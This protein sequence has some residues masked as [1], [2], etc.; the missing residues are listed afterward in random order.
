MFNLTTLQKQAL[1]Q[2]F[3]F[4]PIS[5]AKLS[6]EWLGRAKLTIYRQVLPSKAF[7][8]CNTFLKALHQVF[9]FNALKLPPLLSFII[10]SHHFEPWH[11]HTSYTGRCPK[12]TTQ[13]TALRRK[14][15]P[16]RP[17][18]NTG[19]TT[20]PICCERRPAS[21]KANWPGS[22]QPDA[23]RGEGHTLFLLLTN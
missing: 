20:S 2:F 4:Y 7:P 13:D 6:V 14:T 11:T 21:S 23:E 3:F 15:Q 1:F 9:H 16:A 18:P 22:H 19:L 8:S 12:A 10:H 17:Q 5:K